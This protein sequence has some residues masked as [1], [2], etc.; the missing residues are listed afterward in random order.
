M[1]VRNGHLH[2]RVWLPCREPVWTA[3]THHL[4]CIIGGTELK[5][6]LFS[7]FS[8]FLLCLSV[9]G[10][11]QPAEA[12]YEYN[13]YNTEMTA[14][15][16]YL[17]FR[18]AVYPRTH[19]ARTEGVLALSGFAADGGQDIGGNTLYYSQEDQIYSVKV[20]D[21]VTR[22]I[23]GAE[24]KE[25]K[26]GIRGQRPKYHQGKLYVTEVEWDHSGKIILKETIKVYDSSSLEL[27]DSSDHNPE[28]R[29]PDPHGPDFSKAKIRLDPEI[30]RFLKKHRITRSPDDPSTFITNYDDQWIYYVVPYT[31]HIYRTPYSETEYDETK[32]ENITEYFRE[33]LLRDLSGDFFFDIID[34]RIYYASYDC[35]IYKIDTH[36]LT[37]QVIAL[38]R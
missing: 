24:I 1:K 15:E 11:G 34:D 6:I 3:F 33:P 32:R 21:T 4:F 25:K 8:C 29:Y 28:L 14:V 2:C 9:S 26:L 36:D 31:N 10:C 30:D 38:I 35:R 20:D 17:F 37:N 19:G 13:P 22:A 12:D 23:W 7:F 27:L 16:D 18:E 5:Q